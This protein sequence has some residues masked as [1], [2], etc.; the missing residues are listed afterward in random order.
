MENTGTDHQQPDLPSARYPGREVLSK[1]I[2]ITSKQIFRRSLQS[3]RS[4]ENGFSS[5]ALV[6]LLLS[7]SK[8]C[9][10]RSEQ[11]V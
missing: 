2:E 3:W 1:D 8:A 4:P 10:D 9:K 6:L 7:V 5:S 11:R